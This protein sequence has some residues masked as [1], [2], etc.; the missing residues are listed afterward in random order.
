MPLIIGVD[1]GSTGIRVVVY[2]SDGTEVSSGQQKFPTQRTYRGC[3]EQDPT[4]WWNGLLNSMEKALSGLPVQEIKAI[5]VTATGPTLVCSNPDGTPVRP[6]IMWDDTRPV[7][8]VTPLAVS[9][10]S[11]LGKALWLQRYRSEEFKKTDVMCEA[12]DWIIWKLTGQLAANRP[13]YLFNFPGNHEGI[14]KDIYQSIQDK[15]PKRIVEFGQITGMLQSSVV[16]K[17]N[18][19]GSISVINASTDSSVAGLCLGIADEPIIGCLGGS[20]SVIITETSQDVSL[21]NTNLEIYPP[22]LHQSENYGIAGSHL[23]GLVW[24]WWKKIRG[25]ALSNDL[26]DAQSI[27]A[28]SDGITFC[29]WFQ[30]ER[31]PWA[32]PYL[33]GGMWGVLLH[34]EPSHI[35]RAVLESMAYATRAVIDQIYE[36][37]GMKEREIRVAGGLIHMELFNTILA[38][39]LNKPLTVVNLT[40]ASAAGAAILAGRTLGFNFSGSFTSSSFVVEPSQSDVKPYEESYRYYKDTALQM[41]GL[42]HRVNQDYR[43]KHIGMEEL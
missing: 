3:S 15:S 1:C 43:E 11:L 16:N 12:T 27:P 18:L 2:D 5:G 6:A 33:T 31:Q 23:S 20:S 41:K 39:V 14:D 36:I 9:H 29:N 37:P 28:G 19:S 42:M 21:L 34:H 13:A 38:S 24:D 25:D 7:D 8:Y 22:G 10:D 17:F 40:S 26:V 35:T 4:D 32:D 30:G